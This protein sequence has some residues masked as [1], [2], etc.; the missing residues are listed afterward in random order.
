MKRETGEGRGR[1]RGRGRGQSSPPASTVSPRATLAGA[2]AGV[3]SDV[4]VLIRVSGTLY[5]VLTGFDRVT[6]RPGFAA[7]Y[8]TRRL[9]LSAGCGSRTRTCCSPAHAYPLYPIVPLSPCT[10]APPV[11]ARVISATAR[12]LPRGAIASYVCATPP[13]AMHLPV[14][15]G[16][17]AGASNMG[18]V[19]AL[20]LW[21]R[22]CAAGA[23]VTL[24]PVT[25][26]VLV[27]AVLCVRGWPAGVATQGRLRHRHR[28]G[29]GLSSGTHQP[30]VPLLCMSLSVCC[31]VCETKPG[32][33]AV[34]AAA[35]GVHWCRV[36][37]A[38][39]GGCGM[40]P[41]GRHWVV[42]RHWLRR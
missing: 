32:R 4:E 40:E 17:G 37:P 12:L 29:G 22:G 9:A 6:T 14:P 19:M 15:E 27:S 3:R 21:Y 5:A 8:L 38:G 7:S 42:H 25:V 1:G 41:P 33:L 24:T 30:D 11:P 34:G 2:L 35:C 26:R 10:P 31:A 20:K 39:D 16:G 23:G 18:R 13:P 28:P 36:S